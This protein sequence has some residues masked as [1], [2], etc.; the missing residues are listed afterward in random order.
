MVQKNSL[1]KS[2]PIIII[3]GPTASGKTEL[4]INCAKLLNTEIISADSMNVYMDLDIGTAKP[5]L[6]E[7]REV[8]HHLIDVVS[9]F[10]SFSVGDYKELAEPIVNN[11]QENYKTP[12][13]CGGTGFYINSLIFDL[14]Y[15]NV[16]KNLEVREKYND[17]AKK[18]GNVA[19]Y[20]VLKKVD[21]V[22]AEKIHQNDIKRVIRALEIFESGVKK[23][24]IID[25][26]IPKRKY[27][28]FSFAMD[29]DDLYK[30]I[31]KRVDNMIKNGLVDE[32]L[33]LKNKGLSIKH[34]SMQGIG[35]KEILSYLDNQITLNEAIEQI[36]L[37]T[38]HYA[39]R[40]ITFFKK[41]PNL[42][43]LQKDEKNVERIIEEYDRQQNNREL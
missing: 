25:S 10:V 34:Q 43:Y 22:S 13:V 27:L 2:K 14:S 23:S 3:C 37:N 9:P 18:E 29:R 7:R 6:E 12:I 31:D 4:A 35:Y 41:L 38:R 42:I 24:D 5:S 21:P 30:K 1:M 32:V 28:A 33:L 20:S 19:I 17:L 15:G 16:T 8:K 36:K 26:N 39:K 40:Q 11:L